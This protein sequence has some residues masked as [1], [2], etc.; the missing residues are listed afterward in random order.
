M[1]PVHYLLIHCIV[2]LTLIMLAFYA[3]SDDRNQAQAKL[4]DAQAQVERLKHDTGCRVEYSIDG[5]HWT[6]GQDVAC[7]P[8]MRIARLK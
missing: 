5:E 2:S 4:A 8:Y 3:M 6:I 1:K 7:Y